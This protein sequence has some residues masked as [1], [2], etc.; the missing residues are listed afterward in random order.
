MQAAT[1]T[2]ILMIHLVVRSLRN[3]YVRTQLTYDT[4]LVWRS[5]CLCTAG[6]ARNFVFVAGDRCRL[7]ASTCLVIGLICGRTAHIGKRFP[8]GVFSNIF[9]SQ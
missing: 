7:Q 6:H 3:S 8:Q 4:Q 2:I 9:L 1:L 5:D